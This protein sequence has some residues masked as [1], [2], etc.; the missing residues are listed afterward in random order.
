MWGGGITNGGR[1]MCGASGGREEG[2]VGETL[3]DGNVARVEAL[4]AELATWAR[5][6]RGS[7]LAEHEAGV[8]GLVRLALPGLLAEVVGLSTP[9]LDGRHAPLVKVLQDGKVQHTMPHA[10][11]ETQ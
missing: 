7:T 10:Q 8:L 5:G 9:G 4:G 2:P 3:P 1:R 11:R 6:H